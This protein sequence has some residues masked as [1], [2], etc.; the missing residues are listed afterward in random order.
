VLWFAKVASATEATTCADGV[1]AALRF[2][3][4]GTQAGLDGRGQQPEIMGGPE[5]T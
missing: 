1:V 5:L 3:N 4:H 2:A